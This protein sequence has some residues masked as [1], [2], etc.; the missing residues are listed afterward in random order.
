MSEE[1]LVVEYTENVIV[2]CLLTVGEEEVS[3]SWTEDQVKCDVEMGH[4]MVYRNTVMNS[5]FFSS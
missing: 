3:A 5:L 4:Y 2:F 1:E